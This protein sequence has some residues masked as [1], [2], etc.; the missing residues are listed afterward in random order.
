MTEQVSHNGNSESAVEACAAGISGFVRFRADAMTHVDAAIAADG[1]YALPK[2]VR[3]WMLLSGRDANYHEAVAGLI[4]EVERC[5][6]ESAGREQGLLTA[7]KFAHAGKGIEAVTELETLLDQSPCDVL[8]HQIIQEELFWM[9]RADWMRAITVQAAPAWDVTADDYGVFLSLCAFANEEAGYLEEAERCGRR[10]VEMVPADIWGAHAVAHVHM[11]RGDITEG[12][13][14]L[15]GLAPHW[16]EANQ[17]RHHNWWHLCLL[18]LETGDY[19]RI[20]ELLVTEVR[21]PASP[22]VI[23]SPAASI[24]IQDVASVLL[25]LELLGVD[26]GNHWE[27]LAP[28]CAGRVHNHGNAFGNVHDI[29][30]LAATGQLAEADELLSSM[31]ETYLTRE[32]SVALSYQAAAIPVCEAVLAHRKGDYQGV[33]SWLSGVRHDLSLMGASHAQRDVFYQLLVFAARQLGRKDLC[34]V[35]LREITRL[36][37]AGVEGRVAYQV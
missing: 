25:R 6:P 28:V 8:V 16:R 15:E 24:D 10:A 3:A 19:E 29:M 11:M 26:V 17:M 1:E 2:L 18:L 12:I 5:L 30:V 34:A 36:G 21:N 4:H 35:Y 27:V 37:F 32:G 33:L 7:L 14:W 23:E 9:G 20:F 13:A 31:R 22:L